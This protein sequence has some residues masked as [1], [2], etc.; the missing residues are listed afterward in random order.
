[1]LERTEFDK[2]S[3]KQDANEPMNKSMEFSQM[4]YRRSPG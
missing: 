2:E 4:K 3:L 1:M